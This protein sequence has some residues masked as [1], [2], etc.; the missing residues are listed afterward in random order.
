MLC[1]NINIKDV[2][3]ER[4]YH[5]ELYKGSVTTDSQFNYAWC[6]VRSKYQADIRKGIIFLEELYN[7][8]KGNGRRDYLYYLA[9]GNAR[10]KEYRKALEYC[11]AFLNLEP[12]NNQV[13]TLETVIKKRMERDGMMG[14][15]LAGSAILA[16][17]G[18]IGLGFALAKK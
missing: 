10:L 15:A 6:L 18:L 12:S 9:L 8:D 3:F 4:V 14:I 1:N 7:D 11:R 17:G 13:Q 16:V 2:R 5:E